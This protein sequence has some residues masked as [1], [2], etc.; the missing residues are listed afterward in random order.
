VR[1]TPDTGRSDDA[2]LAIRPPAGADAPRL[3]ALVVQLGYPSRAGEIRARI[4]RLVTL[5]DHLLLVAEENGTVIAW[6]HAAE[7]ELFESGRRCEILG[8]VVDTA[9]RR[10]GVGRTL[11]AAV[12]HWARARGLTEVSVR[13]NVV[14]AESHPFYERLGYARA[15]TQHVYRKSL[16][17]DSSRAGAE[18]QA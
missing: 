15:K 12:E 11:V 2:T 3:D 1:R 6:V 16:L 14:R 4:E 10:G 13:S 18:G 5:P 9:R 8:L 7:Q 17:R